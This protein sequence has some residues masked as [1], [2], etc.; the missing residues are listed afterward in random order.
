[1][2]PDF[3]RP[4][5]AI[6]T[7]TTF[8]SLALHKSSL[9]FSFH[10]EV[11]NK[12]SAQILPRIAE[13]FAQADCTAV[14]LGAIVYAKGAGA[15]TG[16]RIGVGVAQGLATPF[17]TP[18]IGVPCLDAVAYQIPNH[19]CVLAATDARM[20]EVFY[21]W[22][23]TKNHRRLSD[24]SVGKASEIALPENQIAENAKGVGNAFALT[25]PPAFSGNLNMPTAADYLALAQS[26]RYV[27][28]APEFA[29]LLYIRDKIALTAAEQAARKVQAA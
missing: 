26:G 29:E 10:K 18:M 20:G 24:Y 2:Q 27:A 16:L 13:L 3:T 12:Q 28:C 21:A 15:F 22:F 25:E 14:D 7:S 1:M 11:G 9:H 6:D 4:I 19:E 8:L 23:D 17:G 5:L